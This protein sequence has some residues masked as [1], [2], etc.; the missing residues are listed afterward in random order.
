MEH[1]REALRQVIEGADFDSPRTLLKT[2]KADAA[3]RIAPGLPYSIATNVAHADI[4]NRQWVG[5]LDG[6]PKTNPFPDFPV[7]K[8]KDWPKVRDSFLATL[9]RAY[10]IACAEPFEHACKTDESAERALLKVAVHTA[11]HLGQIKL[12]KRASR[13]TKKA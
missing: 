4:W 6:K 3:V 13:T 2:V 11:Y 9:E 10:E 1:I 7:V 12:L 8:E 5:R